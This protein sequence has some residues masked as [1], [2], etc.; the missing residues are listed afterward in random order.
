MCGYLIK[1]LPVYNADLYFTTKIVKEHFSYY[2]HT[3]KMVPSLT[4]LTK[5]K[6]LEKLV[7]ALLRG[8][9]IAVFRAMEANG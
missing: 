9:I 5:K 8:D 2:S 6:K 7:L 1:M 4:D 3:H